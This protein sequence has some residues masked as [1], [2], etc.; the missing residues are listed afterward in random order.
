MHR[1]RSDPDGLV[2]RYTRLEDPPMGLPPGERHVSRCLAFGLVDNSGRLQA[3]DEAPRH[4]MFEAVSSGLAKNDV[5]PFIGRNTTPWHKASVGIPKQAFSPRCARWH[6]GIESCCGPTEQ[7]GIKRPRGDRPAEPV[8]R[9][10]RGKGGG[11]KPRDALVNAMFRF[12][13]A[14]LIGMT[15]WPCTITFCFSHHW[16]N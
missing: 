7:G 5:G 1:Q 13:H 9:S 15:C 16:R 10:T 11:A 12:G 4:A 14:Q 2:K 6:T 8:R 3:F